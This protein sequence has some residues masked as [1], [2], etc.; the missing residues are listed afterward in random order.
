MK[1][2]LCLSFLLVILISSGFAQSDTLVI[3]LKSSQIDKIPI[4]QIQKIEFE[5]ITGVEMLTKAIKSLDI[6]GNNPNPFSEQT[7]IEFEI[8][9]TGSVIILIYDNAGSQVQKLVCQDCQ[10]GKNSLQW[11]CLDKNNSR[12]P[13]G[14]YY[15]E[16]R[17]GNEIQS[18]NMILVK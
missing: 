17:F 16:V 1:K 2:A 4:A 11:N 12:V 13:A 3:N 5:N 14:V 6:T 18:K 9:S 15:Y 10:A 8:A 7:N